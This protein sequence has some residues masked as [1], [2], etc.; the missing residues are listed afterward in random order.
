M[1]TMAMRIIEVIVS[2]D[3]LDK[4]LR[5]TRGPD[6][7]DVW[8]IPGSEPG[9]MVVRVL[10]SMTHCQALIDKF[11]GILANDK[12]RIVLIPILAV[13]PEPDESE[14]A[15]PAQPKSSTAAREELYN[16][17]ADGTKVDNAFVLL[18]VLSTLVAG[19]GLVEDN[20]TVVIGAMV[21]APLLGPN[22]AFAFGVALGDHVLMARAIRASSIGLTLSIGVSILAGLVLPV[23]LNS[24]ELIARTT[25]AYDSVAIALASG[26]AAVL[27]LTS[28]LSSVLVGVMVAVALLPPAAACG[29]LLGAGKFALAGGAAV[30]LG[31]NL[32]CVNLAAQVVL[33]S[34]GV[35]PRTWWQKKE[36]HQSVVLNLVLWGILLLIL[37][38]IIYIQSAKAL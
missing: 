1:T 5:A 8:C 7:V 31:V 17:V 20:V 21:I 4:V 37:L 6:V 11:H 27:S 26:A 28:G 35:R 2:K 24:H 15:Q 33:V 38:A 12:H 25:V 30:L 32:V 9:Q 18:I 3:H 13:I 16:T 22:L 36:A 29:L 34:R 14:Q 23:D 10:A 19:L